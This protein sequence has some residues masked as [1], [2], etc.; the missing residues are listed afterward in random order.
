MQYLTNSWIGLVLLAWAIISVIWLT[1][2]IGAA[3]DAREEAN[4]HRAMRRLQRNRIDSMD[5]RIADLVDELQILRSQNEWH[6]L[7]NA[8]LAELE[9]SVRR[10]SHRKLVTNTDKVLDYYRND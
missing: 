3:R 2:A 8:V 5:A 10:P 6:I 1:L 7:G 9:E 4:T